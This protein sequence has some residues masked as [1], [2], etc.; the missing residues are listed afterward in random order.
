MVTSF[1]LDKAA[2]LSEFDSAF[3]CPWTLRS[4]DT[5]LKEFSPYLPAGAEPQECIRY[6][7]PTVPT[8]FWR[9]T[10]DQRASRKEI[11][12]WLESDPQVHNARK[13]GIWT[14]L[15]D[16]IAAF[17]PYYS[18]SEHSAQLDST[19]RSKLEKRFK[20]GKLNF[21][22]CSTTMEM[23][24]DIGGLSAVIMNNAPPSPANYLQRAGRSGRRGEGISF[25]VTL[26]PSSPHGE[27]VYRNPLWP[28]TTKISVPRVGLDSDR[29]VQRHVNALCLGVFLEGQN[30]QKL[31]S[32]WFFEGMENSACPALR[33]LDW[34]RSGALTNSRLVSGLARLVR[35]TALVSLGP[36]RLLERTATALSNAREPWLREVHALRK[37]AE[38]FIGR[39][40]DRSAPAVRAIDWQ[41]QRLEREYLLGELANRQ[42]LPR[43]G[44][45]IGIVS[46]VTTTMEELRRK[47]KQ[48]RNREETLGRRAGFPSRQL[49]IAIREYA[50]GAEMVMGGRVYKSGGVT[51]NWHIPPNAT[52]VREVQSLRHV[53]RCLSCAQTGD[54]P[55]LPGHCAECE[56][57][58]EAKKYLE[59]A[60]FAVEL[61]YKA[62]NNVTAPDFIPVELPWIS[63]PGA[64]WS[65]FEGMVQGRFRYAENGHL[66]Y[67]N[68][69]QNGYG[70][71]ICLR[72]GRAESETGPTSK[73]NIPHGV[74]E[75]HLR[76][77]GGKEADGSS[78]CSGE[79][80]A[81]QRGLAL[82]GGRNT[83][84]F[85]L[86]LAKLR[87]NG[88]ALS[89]A[90][91]LRRAFCLQLGIEEREVGVAARPAIGSGRT[92]TH[93]MFLFDAAEGGNGYVCCNAGA[94]GHCA[95]AGG[96][97][98]A[99]SR[100]CDAR[101]PC[102][103]AHVRYA[104]PVRTS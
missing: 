45:P 37:D 39:N 82:G 27:Q 71:A 78:R 90:I 104:I 53:W 97:Y 1:G 32:R 41:L 13:L 38:A 4:L 18:A 61:T 88:T 64:E 89:I 59:P 56:G 8:P 72:C 31:R 12:S 68:S 22:S 70:Y 44:F 28:F 40:G 87:G 26:C 57:E 14:S 36:N 92:Q 99:V 50:P 84:V 3:I 55:T 15:N 48:E 11:R 35:G 85:E 65:K 5:T 63:C 75:G 74:G 23:G 96:R 91:A 16:R 80:F 98:S 102:L 93:S 73:T 34:C 33:F 95:D 42:F 103:P 66:F 25:A 49:P 81:I 29:L 46:F 79:G 21:L 62:H 51:L 86:Q 10:S 17:S 6:S 83:D 2:I 47:K 20:Q 9:D 100:N 77:R 52:D 76:L 43:Y 69:G 67:G 19:Y 58:L 30:V 94:C 54:S 101:L 60:G 24:V 7:T